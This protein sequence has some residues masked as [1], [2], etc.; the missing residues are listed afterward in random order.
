MKKLVTIGLIQ[1]KVSNNL[2]ANLKNAVKMVTQA[3]K[4]GAKIKGFG[5]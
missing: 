5:G 3:A 4:K 1:N 2:D